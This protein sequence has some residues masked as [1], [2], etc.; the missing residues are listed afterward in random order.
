MSR[1]TV[2]GDEQVIVDGIKATVVPTDADTVDFEFSCP[3]G[4]EYLVI[5]SNGTKEMHDKSIFAGISVFR[6]VDK[7]TGEILFETNDLEGTWG[8]ATCSK[9]SRF[10]SDF[11]KNPQKYFTEFKDC[12]YSN[13]S[14]YNWVNTF[15]YELTVPGIKDIAQRHIERNPSGTADAMI[16]ILKENRRGYPLE[17]IAQFIAGHHEALSQKQ[18]D[19]CYQLMTAIRGGKKASKEFSAFV[20]AKVKK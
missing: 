15:F 18:I 1:I 11:N 5:I 12:E 7:D 17:G 4:Y 20:S 2:T 3:G 13:K 8:A 14:L 6:I 16:K 9:F 19:S 10:C